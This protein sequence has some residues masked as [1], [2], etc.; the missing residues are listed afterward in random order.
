MEQEL[1]QFFLGQQKALAALT[2]DELSGRVANLVQSLLDPP[3]SYTEEA[4][5]FWDSITSAMPFDWTERV[6]AQ[7][8]ELTVSDV[9]SAADDWIFNAS[10]RR[11]ASFMIFSPAY[12]AQLDQLRADVTTGGSQVTGPGEESTF[13]PAV[14]TAS[15]AVEAVF[16]VEE[17]KSHRDSLSMYDTDIPPTELG[18]S[19]RGKE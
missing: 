15:D 16:S 19:I 13:F 4:G 10:S 18:R 6:I 2:Q 9:L 14:G 3:T 1:G 12:Q 5:G 7:L 17:L 8:K 11:S